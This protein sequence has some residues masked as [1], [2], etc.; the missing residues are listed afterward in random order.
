M[1]VCVCVC[2]Y[3]CVYICIRA[4]HHHGSHARTRLHPVER[5]MR[6]SIY[7][8]IGFTRSFRYQITLSLCIPEM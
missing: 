5:Y 4:H 1:C 8:S 7:L 2:V 6:I 3:V